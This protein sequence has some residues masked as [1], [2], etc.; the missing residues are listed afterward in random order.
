MKR[1]ARKRGPTSSDQQNDLVDETAHDLTVINTQ[2]NERLVPLLSKLPDGS[3][4]TPGAAVDAFDNGLDGKT[5]FSD[6]DSTTAL[7]TKYFNTSANRPRT[8]KEQ[9]EDI[10]TEIA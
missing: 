8:L 2:W 6:A 3:E 10:Y 9:L 5:L 7:E 4:G 1:N